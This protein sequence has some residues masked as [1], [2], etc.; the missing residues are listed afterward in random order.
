MGYLWKHTTKKDL[1]AELISPSTWQTTVGETVRRTVEK[2]RLVGNQLWTINRVEKDGVFMDRFIA[3]D[4]IAVRDGMV[5]YNGYTEEDHPFY[6]T[7]PPAWF[8]EVPCPDSEGARAFRAAVLE[9]NAALKTA[10]RFK[11]GDRIQYEKGIRFADGV[12]E[13]MFLVNKIGRTFEF[14]RAS[15]GRLVRGVGKMLR[16]GGVRV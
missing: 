11:D 2:H 9:A 6:Y 14:R 10:I 12:T 16:Y 8:D 15:D 3:L 13:T 4:L 1:I 7:V 5:G